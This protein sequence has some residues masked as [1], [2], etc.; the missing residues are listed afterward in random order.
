MPGYTMT[1][2]EGRYSEFPAQKL[3]RWGRGRGGR[4]VTTQGSM[5]FVQ[6]RKCFAGLTGHVV[7]TESK[8][9]IYLI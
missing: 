8:C 7:Q 1:R 2:T 3:D 9:I 5:K 4:V 6:D